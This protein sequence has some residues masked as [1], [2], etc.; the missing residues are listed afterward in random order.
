M[1]LRTQAMDKVDYW[2]DYVA[3]DKDRQDI[4]DYCK[5]NPEK[6]GL[7]PV[8][9]CKSTLRQPQSIHPFR[10]PARGP[11]D[12]YR[13][14]RGRGDGGLRDGGALLLALRLVCSPPRLAS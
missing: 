5:A 7:R 3:P 14:D 11:D 10:G 13:D 1:W 2:A 12:A 8:P 6:A 4:L 9:R